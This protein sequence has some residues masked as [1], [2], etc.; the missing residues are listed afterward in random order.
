M[1]YAASLPD[2]QVPHSVSSAEMLKAGFHK[3]TS[4]AMICLSDICRF[5][6]FIIDYMDSIRIHIDSYG[7]HKDSIRI[8]LSIMGSYDL[9]CLE[10]KVAGCVGW[11]RAKMGS[12]GIAPRAWRVCNRF[13]L[14]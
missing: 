8:P 7:F 4:T 3:A 10:A 2:Q 13:G 9:R 11:I 12:A 5:K 14:S 1:Q 6:N